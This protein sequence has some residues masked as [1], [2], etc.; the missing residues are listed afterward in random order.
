MQAVYQDESGPAKI[1][2]SLLRVKESHLWDLDGF[3]VQ[4]TKY[5]KPEWILWIGYLGI[6]KV[7]CKDGGISIQHRNK[8]ESVVLQSVNGLS[9]DRNGL[10]SLNFKSVAEQNGNF[11][12][13]EQ[14][15]K[16]NSLGRLLPGLSYKND[17][18]F[19]ILGTDEVF[20]AVDMVQGLDEDGFLVVK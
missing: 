10:I 2:S 3:V 16:K 15:F 4:D 9:T 20:D 17:P 12:E 14:G 11:D 19:G 13:M 8:D 7:E 1:W 5:L 6:C 18:Q